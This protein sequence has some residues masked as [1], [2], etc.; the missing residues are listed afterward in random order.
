M[1]PASLADRFVQLLGLTTRP[2]ALAFTDV[3]PA[4]LARVASPAPAGCG[5]WK[6][7]A[8]GE[9]FYTV[10]EDHLGCA[11]GAH[12]HGVPLGPEGQKELAGLVETMVGLAYL[13]LDDVAKIP[14]RREGFGALSYGP[15]GELDLAPDVVLVRGSPRA[16]ML[17]AEACHAAGVRGDHAPVLRPACG[18][19]PE[20]LSSRRA[21]DSFGC[22]GNRVYTDLPD[23]EAWFALPG[24]AVEAVAERL[25]VLVTANRELERFH[26][27]RARAAV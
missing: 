14:V 24:S 8:A 27:D 4:G 20:V 19:V 3:P 5:Y 13:T 7:A 17:L 21:A 23:G 15:L 16:G 6:R 12:T 10:P 22:I 26:R 1:S 11:V 18:M 9:C 2:I 25:E